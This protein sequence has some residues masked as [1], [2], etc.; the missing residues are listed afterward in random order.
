M[1]ALLY[2]LTPPLWCV[3]FVIGFVTYRPAPVLVEYGVTITR[4]EKGWMA[5]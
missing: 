4:P 3:G 5:Q 1:T 2:V